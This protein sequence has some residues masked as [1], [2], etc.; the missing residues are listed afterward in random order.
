MNDNKTKIRLVFIPYLIISLATVI[1]WAFLHWLLFIKLN[2]YEGNEGVLVYVIP[3]VLSV[4]SFFIWLDKRIDLLKIGL[5]YDLLY[6]LVPLVAMGGLCF[7]T[8]YIVL[9]TNKETNLSSIS[10]I[11]KKEPTK[12][13]SLKNFYLDKKHLSIKKQFSQSSGKYTR[14]LE[15]SFY[16]VVPI[17]NSVKDTLGSNCIGWYGAQYDN[18]ARDFLDHHDVKRSWY[19][20]GYVFN[21]IGIDTIEN[22]K[23]VKKFTH[24]CM[25][26]FDDPNIN[27]FLYLERIGKTDVDYDNYIL[28]I[29]NN[30]KYDTKSDV[31]LLPYNESFIDR[32]NENLIYALAIFGIGSLLFLIMVINA[33]LKSEGEV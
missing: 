28:A 16:I 27:R 6:T 11:D 33:D 29:K 2:L 4:T 20:T 3:L 23:E 18:T 31:V 30:T 5:E 25:M 19:T 9:K 32:A 15:M 12:F 10:Q 13:Y 21:D 1:G 24:E 7:F 22:S 14:H 17:L 26:K 8:Q